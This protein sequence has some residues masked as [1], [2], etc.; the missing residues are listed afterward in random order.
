MNC[1]H[2]QASRPSVPFPSSVVHGVQVFSRLSL[3][4]DIARECGGTAHIKGAC[5]IFGDSRMIDVVI[6]LPRSGKLFAVD[7]TVVTPLTP[8]TNFVNHTLRVPPQ[9]HR[10]LQLTLQQR[11]RPAAVCARPPV[12]PPLPSVWAGV[13]TLPPAGDASRRVATAPARMQSTSSWPGEGHGG[14]GGGGECCDRW[15][16]GPRGEVAHRVRTIIS[17]FACPPRASPAACG[18]GSCCGATVVAG[19]ERAAPRIHPGRP[20]WVMQQR[21]TSATYRRRLLP[22]A[23]LQT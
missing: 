3:L 13:L 12:S 17:P 22:S 10:T 18:V 14:R 8:A 19:A 6:K 20:H 5:T 16:L 1:S 23:P 4:C 2:V 15:V 21:T 7:V 11:A 9:Q